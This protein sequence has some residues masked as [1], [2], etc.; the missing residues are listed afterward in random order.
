M[1]H[2]TGYRL[3]L[4]LV[5]ST[6][7][8]IIDALRQV[9]LNNDSAVP[10]PFSH[11]FF[12]AGSH[13]GL[14]G[15]G[16]S[17]FVFTRDNHGQSLASPAPLARVRFWRNKANQWEIQAFGS[18]KQFGSSFERLLDWLMP[19]IELQPFPLLAI[20]SE[21]DT[22]APLPVD[23]NE[24]VV[25]FFGSSPE[26]GALTHVMCLASEGFWKRTVVGRLDDLILV[27][28]G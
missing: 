19:W 28:D 2:Y 23:P 11:A 6:P 26:H 8:E 10:L 12:Q 3:S 16:S 22:C 21:E 1:G 25:G 24:G 9:L 14:F 13:K 7:V 4:R 5:P 17:Y 27:G 20:Q 18:T 15:G